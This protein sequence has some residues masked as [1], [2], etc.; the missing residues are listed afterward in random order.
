MITL[1]YPIICIGKQGKALFLKLH[2]S[3]HPYKLEFVNLPDRKRK[4][5]HSFYI[6]LYSLT[7]HFILTNFDLSFYS[8]THQLF[9]DI[10]IIFKLIQGTQINT[11]VEHLKL[12]LEKA[13]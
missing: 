6:I 5:D 10:N 2:F 13:D 9:Q 8:T 3:C 4:P 1:N 7:Y 12:S 11:Q